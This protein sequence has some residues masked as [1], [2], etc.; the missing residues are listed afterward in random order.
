MR[1]FIPDAEAS[2]LSDL[3]SP[4][5]PGQQ[6]AGTRAP[7]T[8]VPPPL[9]PVT[10]ALALAAC[11]GSESGTT[12]SGTPAATQPVVVAPTPVRASRFL[13]QATT[14][15]SKADITALASSSFPVWLNTQLGMARPQTFTG[16]LDANGFNAAT[17]IN[18]QNGLDAMIWAQLMGSPDT[19]RQRVGLALLG[20]WVVGVDGLTGNWRSYNLAAYLDVLWNNAFGNY[21]DLMEGVT[22]SVAMGQ[23]LTYLGS[24]KAVRNTVPDENYARE[25]M[26]L[27]TI[28]LVQLN[29]DGT[30]ILQNGAPVESYKL[31]DVSQL[32]RVWTGYT[33]AISDSTTPDRVRLPMIVNETQ[34]ETGASVFLDISIPA[35]NDGATSRKLALDGLFNHPNMP[36]F[37][38]KQLIQRLV[39]SNP[40]PAYVERVARVFANNGNGIRGDLK[41]V[42]RAILLDT[43]ARDDAA[44]LASNIS[45]RLRE[46]VL[47]LTQWARAFGVTSPNNLWPFGST[48]SPVTRLG[49][50]PG[51]APSVFNWF[52]PAYTPPGTP[53]ATAGLVAPEFQLT[54]EQSVIGY[55]NYIQSVITNGAGEAQPDY[56][57]LLELASDTQV[58]LD[59]LN[60]VLAAGQISAATIAQMKAALDTI[61]NTLP[62]GPR[63]RVRAALVLVMAAPEYLVVQ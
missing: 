41:A 21:R 50:S 7:S 43:E 47:R 46:P 37:V 56:T 14:G 58:L 26:Q 52:R 11:G 62:N 10:A 44:A 54:T 39:T 27:F 5:L 60:L 28:G 51:R 31:S 6:D 17:N 2:A 23:F 45:G 30:P 4:E 20:L 8:G 3:L 16:W 32:A 12:T 34:H 24:T 35:G 18:T 55:V 1:Q 59:E 36:P 19:L 49:Q 53:V 38:S 40:T 57:V 13:S 48:T 63:N 33:F 9:L 42:V 25:L 29:M 22:T 61:A 15:A